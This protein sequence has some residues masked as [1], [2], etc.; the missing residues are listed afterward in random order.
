VKRPL[1]LI[2]IFISLILGRAEAGYFSSGVIIKNNAE[3][4]I[5][6]TRL[7]HARIL[8]AWTGEWYTSAGFEAGSLCECLYDWPYCPYLRP[9]S[10]PPTCTPRP[11]P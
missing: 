7:C 3:A 11:N 10:N 6:C 4:Y 9:G 5:V 2:I 8:G 1:S